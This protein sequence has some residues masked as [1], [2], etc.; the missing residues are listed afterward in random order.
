[1][2]PTK[3]TTTFTSYYNPRERGMVIG[4]GKIDNG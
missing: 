4:K 2:L 3:I 1:M